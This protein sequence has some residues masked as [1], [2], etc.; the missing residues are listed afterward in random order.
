MESEISQ[1][2]KERLKKS[3][4]KQVSV[5]LTNGFRYDGKITN[6]DDKYLEILTRDKGVYKIILI[7]QINDMTIF[8][9]EDGK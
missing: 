6:C 3:E 1:T 7:S 8:D 4:G 2:I 5:F 9:R